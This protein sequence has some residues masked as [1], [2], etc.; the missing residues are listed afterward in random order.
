MKKIQQF[1]EET[2]VISLALLALPLSAAALFE[3]GL[4]AVQALICQVRNWIFTF[5]LII[6]VIYILIAA[7]KYMNSGGD[8]GKVSEVHKALVWAAI[9]IAVA[10]VAAAVPSLVNSIL[11]GGDLPSGC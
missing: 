4:P 5:A 2:F 8:A 10:L 1:L 6:G 3:G 7:V 9:G 11:G